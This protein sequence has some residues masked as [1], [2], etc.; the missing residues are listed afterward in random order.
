MA[1]ILEHDSMLA[2]QMEVMEANRRSHVVAGMSTPA[3]LSSSLLDVPYLVSSASNTNLHHQQV[4]HH[5]LSSHSTS[6]ADTQS[7][8]HSSG[9]PGMG[10]SLGGGSINVTHGKP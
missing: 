4:Y 5:R 6:A 8:S 7:H 2:E 3:D 1:G 10:L 9:I